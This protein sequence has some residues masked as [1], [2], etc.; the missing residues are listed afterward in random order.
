MKPDLDMGDALCDGCFTGGNA[1]ARSAIDEAAQRAIHA[2]AALQRPSGELPTFTARH[3]DMRDARP[4]PCSV[5]TTS[6]AVHALRRFTHLPAARAVLHA[7]AAHLRAERN[8]DGAWSYEGRATLR[9]PPDLDD[10]ACAATALLALGEHP[11]LA[12]FRLLWENEAAPGGP[13]FTWVG[14]NTGEH[15]L[16]RQ[17]DALVNAN[18]VL[19][20]A[21]AGQTLPGTLAYLLDSCLH[22]SLDTASVFCL[23]PHLLAYALARAYADGPAPALEPAVRAAVAQLDGSADAFALACRANVLLALADHEGALPL[24]RGLLEAQ[25]GDGSW[26]IAAAY[27]GYPPHH[28]GSPALTTAIALDALGRALVAHHS[29]GCGCLFQV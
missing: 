11:G 18:I 13:F 23:R 26:P 10:T 2:L 4:Y 21:L 16:A 6:F 5:Y 29:K 9:V 22:S 28:D 3:A 8:A 27:S 15:L 24:L 20:A 7:A 1:P 17:L 19:C 12:L 14:I 25:R